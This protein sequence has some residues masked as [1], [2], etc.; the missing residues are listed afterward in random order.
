MENTLSNKI[1]NVWVSDYKTR[2]VISAKA[3]KEFIQ[4]VKLKILY[5]HQGGHSSVSRVCNAEIDK[6]AGEILI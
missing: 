4:E 1:I 6:L 3:V 2:D 5:R